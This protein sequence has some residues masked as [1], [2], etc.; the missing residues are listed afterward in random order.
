MNTFNNAQR[1]I[2]TLMRGKNS[3]AHF[4]ACSHYQQRNYLC[5]RARLKIT[6]RT[7]HALICWGGTVPLL[8]ARGKNHYYY[9][10]IMQNKQQNL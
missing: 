10:K 2:S 8:L 3:K 1:I 9:Y 6:S 4:D 7:I 5:A